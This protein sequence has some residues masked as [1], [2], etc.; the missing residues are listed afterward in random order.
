MDIITSGR[1]LDVTPELR[2]HIENRLR[3]LADEYPKLTTVR[4]VLAIER[5]WHVAEAHLNGKHLTLKARARTPDMY[6]SIDTIADKLEIQLRRHVERLREHRAK[7][8]ASPGA[9][10]EQTGRTEDEFEEE[11][12]SE[13]FLDVAET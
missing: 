5:S 11:E 3:K 8:A 9:D 1:N 12:I 10:V 2:L 4:I 6:T 7:R 13:E